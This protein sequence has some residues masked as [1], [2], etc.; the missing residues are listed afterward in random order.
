MLQSRICNARLFSRHDLALIP[1]QGIIGF[2]ESAPVEN[3]WKLT[4]ILKKAGTEIQVQADAEAVIPPWY[5]PPESVD[6]VLLGNRLGTTALIAHQS[7][8]ITVEIA[9]EVMRQLE[10]TRLS[11]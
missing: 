1:V 4:L 6:V 8:L 2:I 7:Q 10:D 3:G 11:A 5:K 9:A